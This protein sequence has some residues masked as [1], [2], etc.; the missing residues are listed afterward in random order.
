M[1]L[2][3]AQ[4]KKNEAASGG[5]Q[6]RY[7]GSRPG[8]SAGFTHSSAAGHLG[9]GGFV[10]GQFGAASHGLVGQH[11]VVG[12]HLGGQQFG[13]RPGVVGSGFVG[14]PGVGGGGFGGQGFVGQPGV[15]G[16]YVGQPGFGGQPGVGGGYVG[17]PGVGIGGGFVGQPGVGGG[18]VGQPG[19]G[20]GF[21][22]QPGV[23][24]IH[25]GGFVGQPGVGVGGIHGGGFVGQPGV[26]GVGVGAHGG[27]QVIGGVETSPALQ[28]NCAK[29]ASTSQYGIDKTCKKFCKAPQQYFGGQYLCCDERTVGKCPAVRAQCPNHIRGLGPVCCF[30]DSQC[31]RPTEKCCYDTCLKHKVCK[32]S[33]PW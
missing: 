14:R 3:V 13:G 11:G 20:G 21:V 28:Y 10:G 31:K 2:A 25:G 1:A 9:Q 23:G 22:G 6:V 27:T 32:E 26:H 18:F 4:D 19:V 7:G 8:G 30:V 29:T 17:Q 33:T 12:S 15:G 16:G 5:Q 24:G